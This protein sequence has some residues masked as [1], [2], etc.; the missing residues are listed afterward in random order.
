MI[1]RR[2]GGEISPPGRSVL[3]YVMSGLREPF[4]CST[5]TVHISSLCSI[6]RV[7]YEHIPYGSMPHCRKGVTDTSQ[8]QGSSI[9]C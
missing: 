3:S 1:L 7:Q 4:S 5:C 2:C 9:S 6:L 8:P